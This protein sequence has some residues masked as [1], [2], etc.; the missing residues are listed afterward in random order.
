VDSLLPADAVE[1]SYVCFAGQDWWYH[2]RAHSDVQLMLE[3]SR[4]RKVLLVNSI[5]LRMPTRNNTTKPTARVL[6]K[7]RSMARPLQRPVPGNPNFYVMSPI[8][9][10]IYGNRAGRHAIGILVAL[11]VRFAQ[12]RIGVSAPVYCATLPTAV[13]AI[14]VLRGRSIVVYNRSDPHADFP[15]ADAGVLL[16]IEAEMFAASDLVIYAS[17]QLRER[18]RDRARGSSL[19]IDH[20]VD[21]TAFRPEA[22]AQAPADIRRIPM[23]RLGFFGQL[24]RDLVDVPLIRELA[25]R[26]PSAS[27]VLIGATPEPLPELADK[28]NI[29]LLGEK[30]HQEI[31]AYGRQFDVALLPKP[32]TS[33]M[34]NSNPIKLKEYLALGLPV[35]STDI[36]E[37]YRYPAAVAVA[38]DPADFASKV[39]ETLDISSSWQPE[40]AR[41]LVR[42]QSWAEKAK[43]L[44]HAVRVA[45]GTRRAGRRIFGRIG[46]DAITEEEAVRHVMSEL[47][48]GNGGII[49]TPNID[50][51]A[52]AA[53]H[54]ALN[55]LFDNAT[56]V[57]PDGAPLV[58]AARISGRPLP[59]RVTGADLLWS[60]TAAE[61]SRTGGGGVFLLGG[62]A[63][64]ATRAA[65]HLEKQFPNLRA[66]GTHCPPH[67]FE[68]EASQI[69]QII[70][71]IDEYRP[72]VVFC[73][74]GFPKQE[75]LAAELARWFP[76]TWFVSCGAAIDFAAGDV[77]RAPHWMRETGLE[78]LY[79]LVSEPN[80]LA[81]RYLCR[82]LPFAAKLLL[83]A[84]LHV[85]PR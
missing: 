82:D 70:A 5:G 57:L 34:M 6:R 49:V 19:V 36:P 26:L 13:D 23:P 14:K 22:D 17:E 71:A 30:Q 25:D 64:A 65:R 77:P 27:I 4:T 68:Y 7:L 21:L 59:E 73:G 75:G 84:V 8:A 18:E 69:D 58:L 83:Q 76:R 43:S 66:P 39:K 3:M 85:A 16:K 54:G 48:A 56:L 67:G 11:Q 47:Q 78:W 28:P 61:A 53:K 33:W 37:A 80:R 15:E 63:G 72:S 52:Q 46:V 24:G 9:L 40:T 10:P 29:F 74:L 45:A 31:P 20:G 2:S 44:D 50:Q 55:E 38:K 51:L 81:R 35:V 1:Y 32:T 62:A 12:W 60:L 42:D 79:R 41:D